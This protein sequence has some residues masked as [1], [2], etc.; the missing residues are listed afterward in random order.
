MKDGRIGL[1]MSDETDP[2][3]LSANLPP[4]SLERLAARRGYALES[5]KKIALATAE[6]VQATRSAIRRTDKLIEQLAE[7]TGQRLR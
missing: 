4:H 3:R 5:V 7:S 1:D 6:R 2:P